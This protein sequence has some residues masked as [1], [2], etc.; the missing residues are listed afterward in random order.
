MSANRRRSEHDRRREL[1]QNF[2]VDRRAVDRFIARLD[3]AP[4]ELV[5]DIGA[6]SGALTFPLADAGAD[7]WAVEIDPVLVDRLR[8]EVV[9]RGL[10]DRVRVIGTDLH[11]LRLPATAYRVAANPPFGS[12]TA[13]LG[14][15]LDRPDRGPTRADLIVQDDVARKRSAV[16]PTTLRSAAWAPWWEFELGPAILRQSFRPVPRVDAAVLTI[17]RRTPPI[18]PERLAPT[19]R[20]TLRRSW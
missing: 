10:D 8:S 4:G 17:T 6:G 14:L 9:R 13:L 11:R 3:V 2:L 16:P 12:T 20:E 19:M 18:L 1:G 5:V 15:L 7:V